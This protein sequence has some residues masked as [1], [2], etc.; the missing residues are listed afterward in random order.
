MKDI[1]I[2]TLDKIADDTHRQSAR[3][4]FGWLASNKINLSGKV[5]D[6]RCGM[7]HAADDG[8]WFVDVNVQYDE[9]L[10][11][12]TANESDELRQMLQ[13]RAGHMGCPRCKAGKC[14]YTGIVVANPDE[15]QIELFKRLVMY[16]I[17]AIKEGRI[18]RCSYIKLSK[19]GEALEPCAAHK[20][21]NPKCRTMKNP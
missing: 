4:M 12:F 2:E 7:V 6:K 13:S 8:G 3:E 20:V 5:K 21:C 1:I 11:E 18:P 14:Q 10:D 9:F 15:G 19:R 16:R 17:A